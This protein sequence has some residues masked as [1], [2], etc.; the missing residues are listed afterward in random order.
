MRKTI[1]RVRDARPD[2]SGFT[3]IELLIVIIILGVLAAVVVFS[4]RGI[5]NNSTTAACETEERIV[6]TAIEAYYAETGGY[7]ADLEELVDGNFLKEEPNG[8]YVTGIDTTDPN[9][10]IATSTC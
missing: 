5:T 1:D 7:P 2:Q 8:D 6:N 9:N 10:P 4:V 3:L